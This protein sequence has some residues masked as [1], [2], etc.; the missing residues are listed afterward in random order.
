MLRPEVRL[1]DCFR[2]DLAIRTLTS[3][4]LTTVFTSITFLTAALGLELGTD[5]SRAADD[6]P[7]WKETERWT[8]SYCPGYQMCYTCAENPFGYACQFSRPDEQW[9]QGDCTVPGYPGVTSDCERTFFTCGVLLYC[10]T[11][12]SVV[13]DCFSG[14]RWCKTIP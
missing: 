5:H 6:P 14:G 13:P 1:V 2:G 11:G 7:V 8:K 12:D 3:K 9:A 10:P 4:L